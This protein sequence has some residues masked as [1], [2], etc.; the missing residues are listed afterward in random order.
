M[1]KMFKSPK[2]STPAPAPEIPKTSSE[3][4]AKSVAEVSRSNKVGREQASGQLLAQET[5]TETQTAVTDKV[6]STVTSDPSAMKKKKQAT[7]V[8]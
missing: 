3:E 4:I 6:G 7:L 5:K 2:A 1:S 8:Y